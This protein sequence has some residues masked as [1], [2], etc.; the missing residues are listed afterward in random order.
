MSS[1]DE[2]SGMVPTTIKVRQQRIL[3][4]AIEVMA[5]IGFH[6]FEIGVPQRLLVSVELWLDPP[7][8]PADDD[9][10]RAWDYDVVVQA[11]RSLAMSRRYNL[12]ETLVHAIFARIAS[13][14]G[15]S[16][17]KVSSIK[18]DVYSDASGVGVEI[19]S[20]R[21]AAP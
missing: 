7:V 18:P 11:V 14:H 15:I 3:I 1:P 12:Q 2:L 20:F 19:T 21:G 9:P 13:L 5:D 10:G 16:A 6:D 17:L 4:D 8:P